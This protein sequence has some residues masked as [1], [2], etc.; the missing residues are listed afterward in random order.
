[1]RTN[2]DGRKD[3]LAG[4]TGT[5]LMGGEFSN[6]LGKGFSAGGFDITDDHG[7]AMRWRRR[8]PARVAMWGVLGALQRHL[9]FPVATKLWL[10]ANDHSETGDQVSPGLQV[11]L[12]ELLGG[13]EWRFDSDLREC[14]AGTCLVSSPLGN[15]L[16]MALVHGTWVDG[17]PHGRCTAWFMSSAGPHQGDVEKSL[18]E[19]KRRD[20]AAKEPPLLGKT[21]QDRMRE[22]AAR[23]ATRKLTDEA[24][25]IQLSQKRDA[26]TPADRVT[27]DIENEVQK[28]KEIA[29]AHRAAHVERNAPIRQRQIAKL[30]GVF[31]HGVLC[32]DEDCELVFGA[33]EDYAILD[34]DAAAKKAKKKKPPAGETRAAK[35]KRLKAEKA[36]KDRLREQGI[37]LKG[38]LKGIRKVIYGDGV[39]PLADVE[40]DTVLARHTYRGRFMEEAPPALT[41]TLPSAPGTAWHTHGDNT[42]LQRGEVRS[43]IDERLRKQHARPQKTP[44]EMLQKDPLNDHHGRTGAMRRGWWRDASGVEYE[45]PNVSNLFEPHA[46]SGRRFDVR[47]PIG[48]HYRGGL[49]RG[50]RHGHGRCV[51]S[52]GSVYIGDWVMGHRHG[53][54]TMRISGGKKGKKEKKE[55]QEGV[56]WWMSKDARAAVKYVPGEVLDGGTHTLTQCRGGKY[57]GQWRASMRH[58]HGE[59]LDGSGN[60]YVGQWVAGQRNGVGRWLL[61]NGDTYHGEFKAQ[62]MHGYGKMTFDDGAKESYEGDWELNQPCGNGRLMMREGSM[63]DGPF[64]DGKEHGEGSWA[65]PSS[66]GADL[67][68]RRNGL[69]ENG[70]RVLWLDWNPSKFASQQFLVLM[71]RV[72]RGEDDVGPKNYDRFELQDRST[73]TK[74]TEDQLVLLD[75]S[76]AGTATKDDDGDG[77]VALSLQAALHAVDHFLIRVR[78]AA[79]MAAL[80][81]HNAAE[82]AVSSLRLNK[83]EAFMLGLTDRRPMLYLEEKR[84][85]ASIEEARANLI[86]VRKSMDSVLA[87]E[88]QEVYDIVADAA[89][90]TSTKVAMVEALGDDFNLPVVPKLVDIFAAEMDGTRML[91]DCRARIRKQAL[92]QV[93]KLAWSP[94]F[95]Q[96]PHP[97]KAR[98]EYILRLWLR[99][100]GLAS[101]QA[102]RA[103]IDQGKIGSIEMLTLVETHAELITFG[104]NPK[105][106][107]KLHRCAMEF[108][109][110]KGTILRDGN[111]GNEVESEAVAS[112]LAAQ[113][114]VENERKKDSALS[115]AKSSPRSSAA[116]S[117]RTPR[118][119][120]GGKKGKQ[121]KKKPGKKKSGKVAVLKNKKKK[122]KKKKGDPDDSDAELAP[123]SALELVTALT[124]PADSADAFEAPTNT[125]MDL[126]DWITIEKPRQ[127]ICHLILKFVG[128]APLSLADE[129]AEE[130]EAVNHMT[131]KQR[132]RHVATQEKM[133]QIQKRVLRRLFKEME[134]RSFATWRE[135]VKDQKT[136]RHVVHRV[137]NKTK[138][139][140]FDNWTDWIESGAMGDDECDTFKDEDE[141]IQRLSEST[142]ARMIAEDLPILP[143]GVH[144]SIDL[145][146]ANVAMRIV[147]GL[148]AS[149]GRNTIGVYSTKVERSA[150][151]LHAAESDAYATKAV[152]QGADTFYFFSISSMTEYFTNIMLLL[153]DIFCFRKRF[154]RKSVT[155]FLSKWIR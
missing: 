105:D 101:P 125:A 88:A 143:P 118:N 17:K 30:R 48:E 121:Q 7:W 75:A 131:L 84:H 52:D 119:K 42:T 97:K 15:P 100:L 66:L 139:R 67:M 41:I 109:I 19:K 25:A 78:A 99:E 107:A 110:K 38:V 44:F 55:L 96:T 128:L 132:E 81:A 64:H 63:Y 65:E 147:Q 95:E 20:A 6:H 98:V 111:D 36:R 129:R 135:M 123:S 1:M 106:A 54:G 39:V 61:K 117:P 142:Y 60:K 8:T 127:P 146:I 85:I 37:S 53:K 133:V 56:E 94:D 11:L 150:K 82:G 144:P 12:A 32:G 140:M 87:D 108:A 155:S 4:G 148:G 22:R 34:D 130:E 28:Q 68:I 86:T 76:T 47:N 151:E 74:K 115:S 103:L 45:G 10:D 2:V 40:V 26:M 114:V 134:I 90:E 62:M 14:W 136:L 73:K 124:S 49:V 138:R 113:A 21:W 46:P 35:L 145:E 104:M 79:R 116:S 137:Q 51:Y 13:R 141:R 31:E 102:E 69:W 89:K 58:G 120:R 59:E 43:V 16:G 92:V 72:E 18:V 80:N 112:A 154:S 152:S 29:D 57:V 9:L 5:N 50:K 23:R 3:R 77:D 70:K 71:G 27:F 153:M 126:T 24:A 83:A 33:T 91:A 93:L 122:G 149:A